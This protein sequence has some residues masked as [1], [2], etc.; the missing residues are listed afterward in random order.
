VALCP[1]RD[2]DLAALHIAALARALPIIP[3]N[4]SLTSAEVGAL[5][6]DSR[7][8]LII[9]TARF[10]I[11]CRDAAESLDS[12]WWVTG[13][14]EQVLPPPFLMPIAVNDA[15]TIPTDAADVDEHT[16]A[17]MLYTSGTTGRPKSVPLCHS[18]LHANLDTLGTLWQRGASDRLLHM[19]PAHHFHGLILGLYGSL[20]AGNAMLML[21]RFDARAALDAA[22]E[23][24]VTLLMGVPTMYRRMLDEAQD[25]DDLS[26]LRLALSG[27]A[28]LAADLWEGFSERFGVPLVERYGLTE[29][30]IVTSNPLEAPRA[31]S[32]G[33]VLPGTKLVIRDDDRYVRPV[34]G[35]ESPR[36]EIC[37]AG[38]SVTTGYGNDPDATVAAFHDE[39]FHTGDLGRVDAD[40]YLWIDGRLKDLIIVGGS[41]VI[42]G[43]VERALSWVKGVAELA[44][45][46]IPDADLGEIVA[47][48]VVADSGSIPDTEIE[49]SM[50][51]AAENGLAPYKRPRRYVFVKELPRNA[52][53]KIDR[54]RL[55][56]AA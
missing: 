54:A 41:N 20:L 14:A 10:A 34:R 29:T 4:S 30:G 53:G 21:P 50:T 47:A 48:Y 43:E 36:G 17:V 25:G 56:N 23:L 26:G 51:R 2:L 19:L 18:N 22:R 38:P 24:D 3:L 15:G 28:P 52:M 5:L 40:G 55:R 32:A 8:A 13:E 45:A 6:E 46:G 42:P 11:S 44:V 33:L 31:G 9:S 27:S 16:E 37:V 35:R 7:P 49:Q 1:A 39:L 12:P